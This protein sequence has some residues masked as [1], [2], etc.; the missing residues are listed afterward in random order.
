MG[1]LRLKL[2]PVNLSCL[3]LLNYDDEQMKDGILSCE[4]HS[5]YT[6]RSV[7]ELV[8]SINQEHSI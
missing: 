6:I 3:L 8:Q 2:A 1:A 7:N 4:G 5:E